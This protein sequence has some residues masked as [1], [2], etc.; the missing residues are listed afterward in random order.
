MILETNALKLNPNT[1]GML[2]IAAS[3]VGFFYVYLCLRDGVVLN[4][5]IVIDREKRPRLYWLVIFLYVLF[6]FAILVM[7]IDTMGSGR[8]AA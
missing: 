1:P 5:G 3:T 4:R 7:G 8:P 2:L 6:S